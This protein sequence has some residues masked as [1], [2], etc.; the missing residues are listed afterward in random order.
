MMG[1]REMARERIEDILK[2]RILCCFERTYTILS[3]LAGVEFRFRVRGGVV[4]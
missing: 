2:G 4:L 1:R 3:D